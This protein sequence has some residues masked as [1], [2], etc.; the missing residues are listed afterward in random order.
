MKR[1]VLIIVGGSGYIGAHVA[2]AFVGAGYHVVILDPQCISNF[3]LTSG[4]VVQGQIGDY[5]LLLSLF[6][7]NRFDFVIHCAWLSDETQSYSMPAVWY[8]NHL[9]ETIV[10][11]TVMKEEA[12]NKIIFTSSASVY[13]DV[14]EQ[15]I[16]ETHSLDPISPFGRVKYA[17]ETMF[18]DY[19]YA[20]G[21][22]YIILRLFTVSGVIEGI[23]PDI[24][25][26][27]SLALESMIRDEAFS[28]SRGLDTYDGSL[29]RDFIHVTD[30]ACAYILAANHLLEQSVSEICNLGTGKRTSYLELIRIIEQHSGRIIKLQTKKGFVQESKCLVADSSW[31]KMIL[32]FSPECSDMDIIIRSIAKHK[33]IFLEQKNTTSF[34]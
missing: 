4:E 20:Y 29:E 27:I 2:Q 26:P 18:L 17:L 11:L 13:G 34:V 33:G 32:G 21:L 3:L 6:K 31:A 30:V 10:L 16:T 5:A 14:Y 15:Y 1:T 7:K 12:C 19:A 25:D 24:L 9:V 8:E 22:Q 28:L 23:A